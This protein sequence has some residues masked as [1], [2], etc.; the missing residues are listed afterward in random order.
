[1]RLHLI[2]MLCLVVVL[3]FPISTLASTCFG[4]SD[5]C[6]WTI[7]YE[8]EFNMTGWLAVC[9]DGHTV[10]NGHLGGDHVLDMCFL[11]TDNYY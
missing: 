10:V 11:Y 7:I 5:G 6:Y 3:T 8:P 2:P 9:D 1:M 4:Y